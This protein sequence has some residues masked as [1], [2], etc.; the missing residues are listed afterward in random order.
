[1]GGR[2]PPSALI[3]SDFRFMI[4]NFRIIFYVHKSKI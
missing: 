4:L 2:V 3:I 1:M